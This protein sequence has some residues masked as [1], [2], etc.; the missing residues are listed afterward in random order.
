MPLSIYLDTNVL[1]A[2]LCPEPESETALSWY[3][4][5]EQSDLVSSPWL[6]AELGSALAQKQR[7]RQ[8]TVREMN[9]VHAQAL[10]ILS[11]M[12]CVDILSSDFDQAAALCLATP[13]AGLRTP[14]ALHL[15][16]AQRHGCDEIASFD[17]VMQQVARQLGFQTTSFSV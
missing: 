1:M 5:T 10:R 4:G 9:T 7:K 12:R 6:R 2:L 15:A 14:D 16:I 13:A 3:L 17:L 8:L 11:G